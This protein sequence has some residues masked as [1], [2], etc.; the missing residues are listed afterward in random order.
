MTCI[1]PGIEQKLAAMLPDKEL[2]PWAWD[3]MHNAR[4]GYPLLVL[5]MY[6]H[7]YHM[8]YGEVIRIISARIATSR[9][10]RDYE[11]GKE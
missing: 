3:H 9:E 10:R 2:P 6:E 1:R 7:A 8:D 11:R 4:M 5:D